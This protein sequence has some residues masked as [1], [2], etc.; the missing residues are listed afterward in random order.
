MSRVN[1]VIL[2]SRDIKEH[3]LNNQIEKL[4]A[5]IGDYNDD[6]EIDTNFISKNDP[7]FLEELR[8]QVQR[9]YQDIEYFENLAVRN[10]Q[11]RQTEYYYKARKYESLAGIPHYGSACI[12]SDE[13]SEYGP[14]EIEQMIN[15]PEK[16]NYTG[17]LIVT[18]HY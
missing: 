11:D 18:I 16:I 7:R 15:N 5:I 2:T 14:E 13:W 8:K 9:I 6:I 17:L 10:G 3:P 12:I 4:T 1:C